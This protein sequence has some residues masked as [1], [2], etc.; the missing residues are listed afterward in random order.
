M[1]IA[2]EQ[3]FD[4]KLLLR[5]LPN[6]TQPLFFVLSYHMME[7]EI[8]IDRINASREFLLSRKKKN[9]S[10]LRVKCELLTDVHSYIIAWTN[11]DKTLGKLISM[12]PDTNFRKIYNKRK[13]WF[14]RTREA[15][16]HL[17]HLE[18]RI[19]GRFKINRT[20]KIAG[21]L[22]KSYATVSIVGER[23][24]I[25]VRMERKSLLLL[26]ELDI[27]L[28]GL[29]EKRGSFINGLE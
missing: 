5:D 17:E 16:N 24:D 28:D 25:G 11:I 14:K 21:F 29:P 26:L 22:T 1:V 4:W 8:L 9:D 13:K 10:F 20:Y 12:I 2:P 18:T 23:I 3:R 19:T 27:W 7:L 15:R 6:G